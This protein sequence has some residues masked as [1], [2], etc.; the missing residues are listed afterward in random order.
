MPQ[1][2][3]AHPTSAF[4]YLDLNTIDSW[5]SSV[6][7]KLLACPFGGKAFNPELHNSIRNKIFAAATKISHSTELGILA[8]QPS[9][10]ALRTN[11]TPTTFLIYNLTEHQYQ[12]L[13]QRGTWSSLTISFCVTPLLPTCP[14]Y[15]FSIRNLTMLNTTE[16]YN[17]IRP[18]WQDE[19]LVEFLSSILQNTPESARDRTTEALQAFVASMNVEIL[20]T[21]DSGD[22][23]FPHFN[24]Y[25][26]HL[27]N[28]DDDTW[29]GLRLF[30][31]NRTYAS[32][33]LGVA[34]NKIAPFHCGICHGVDHP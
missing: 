21:K 6:G 25:T 5:E 24:I 4:D 1:I 11:R 14:Q 7:H 29:S 20:P 33:K 19:T 8:P 26:T 16:V 30:F 32:Q 12:L 28:L 17:T 18:V 22:T 34:S 2:H 27:I 23:P 3:D 31:A 9:E 13:L 10:E 15:L